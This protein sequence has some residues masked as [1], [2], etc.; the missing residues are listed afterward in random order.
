MIFRRKRSEVPQEKFENGF[1]AHGVEVGRP[2]RVLTTVLSI[3]FEGRRKFKSVS[4]HL[5]GRPKNGFGK[6]VL[7]LETRE[8]ADDAIGRFFTELD[9]LGEFVEGANFAF[10]NGDGND[11]FVFAGALRE[12]NK[13]FPSDLKLALV[14]VGDEIS[15]TDVGIN[16][17]SEVGGSNGGGENGLRFAFLKFGIVINGSKHGADERGRAFA[18]NLR[19]TFL[20]A[21]LFD[22]DSKI[23]HEKSPPVMSDNDKF[24][25]IVRIESVAVRKTV[26][27]LDDPSAFVLIEND[28]I[29]SSVERS[30]LRSAN[31]NI[32]FENVSA[33]RIAKPRKLFN[34][35]GFDGNDVDVRFG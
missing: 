14:A 25:G 18:E 10:A 34:E 8:K 13:S 23:R 5:L 28:D 32:A 22:D 15:L 19:E 26:V 27:G 11:R 12:L 2:T 1:S 21:V 20:N 3:G 24:I 16:G 31:E 29:M 30:E 33:L 7:E 35:L 17:K 6:A 9:R 4:F